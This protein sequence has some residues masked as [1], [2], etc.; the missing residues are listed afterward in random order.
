MLRL[1][2]SSIFAGALIVGPLAAPVLAAGGDGNSAPKPTQTTKECK[3]NKVWSEKK[4]RCVNPENSGLSDDILY[5]AVR[6]LA[7]AGRLEA[8]QGALTAMRVQND[9][10]VQTYWGFTHRKLGNIALGMMFYDRA[11]TANPDN[12]LARS[13]LGQAHVQAG[14]LKLARAQL[15]EIRARGGTDSWAE[16]SLAS[17]IQTGMTFN[18]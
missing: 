7:H 5:D 2:M 8:A 1:L 14:N 15:S 16:T 12:L 18:Y 10:R 3:K 9:D 11:L 17:A 4:K 13:Y 6:E